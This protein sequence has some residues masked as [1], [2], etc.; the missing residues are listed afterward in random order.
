MFSTWTSEYGDS[1]NASTSGRRSFRQT[2][3][4]RCSRSRRDAVGDRAERPAAAGNHDHS[5]RRIGT[6]GDRR[7]HV[8]VVVED[9]ARALRLRSPES[10]DPILRASRC[11]RAIS[12]RATSRAGSERTR[13]SF[14]RPGG[15]ERHL[16]EP[17]GELRAGAARDADDDFRPAVCPA[18]TWDHGGQSTRGSDKKLDRCPD[19]SGVRATPF[20]STT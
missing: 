14:A 7:A 10:G 12:L 19:G 18:A 11:S 8:A 20:D 15:G 17:A 5:G 6:R 9:D 16:D 3:A 13:W 2:S 4:A 1:R